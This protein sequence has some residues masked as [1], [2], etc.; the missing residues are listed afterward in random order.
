MSSIDAI[1]RLAS[2]RGCVACIG[3]FDG[4][5]RGHQALLAQASARARNHDVPLVALTFDPNPVAVVRPEYA[6]TSLATLEH[7]I[8]LLLAAGADEVDV[9]PFD[10]ALAAMEP[11][12]FVHEVLVAR[13]GVRE[14]V[15]GEN[16]RF[17]HRAAGNIETLRADGERWGFTVTPAPLAG[18]GSQR[19]SST[20]ARALVAGGEVAAA[21]DVLGRPYRLDGVVVHGDHRGRELGY[22]TA[23]LAWAG[24]PTIPADGVYA[25]WV[26]ALGQ[27]L[28]AAISVGSNPQF[29]GV[30][31]RVE[32][33]VLDRHDLDLYGEDIQ[34]EFV[35]RIR[36]QRTF[37]GVDSLVVRIGQDVEEAR[38][39]LDTRA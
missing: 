39:L 33:Y 35:E 17:G 38:I 9:L 4:V 10:L 20:Y 34:V 22:P 11:S 25:G 32:S 15:V 14:V 27:S 30:E 3:V 18:D 13:L 29:A 28:P 24:T 12:Q 19:W 31:R 21:R 2:P 16:F 8:E 7:R 23:N 1:A 37:D 6:P 5:H 26:G 36:G